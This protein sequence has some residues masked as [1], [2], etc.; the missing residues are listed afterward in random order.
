LHRGGVLL[1]G[2]VMHLRFAAF[3]SRDPTKSLLLSVFTGHPLVLLQATGWLTD[4]GRAVCNALMGCAVGG[5]LIGSG[6]LRG[7]LLPACTLCMQGH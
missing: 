6:G 5:W 1:P 4:A 7:A 2:T 3:W